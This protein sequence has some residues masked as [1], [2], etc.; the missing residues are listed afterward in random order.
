MKTNLLKKIVNIKP[1]SKANL[2][3]RI[4][5]V[6]GAFI[7]K[8]QSEIIGKE[9]IVFDDIYTTGSTANECKKILI[10]SGA[11]KVAIMT[12]SRKFI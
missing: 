8:N 9:I 10:E 4:E 3:N 6:K 5:N 2:E 11:K 12:F 1:Q 7:C